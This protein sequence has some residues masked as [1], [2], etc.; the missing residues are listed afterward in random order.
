[1]KLFIVLSLCFIMWNASA[2]SSFHTVDEVSVTPLDVKDWLVAFLDGFD[3]EKYANSTA[4]C[5]KEGG[6][7]YDFAAAGVEN[8]LKKNYF[9]GSLNI[10]DALGELSP[11]SRTCYD[12]TEQLAKNFDEYIH[13]FSG[14]SDFFTKISLN[15]M[16]NIKPIKS[17]AT[18]ILTEYLVGGNYTHMAFLSGQIASLTF[19]I[20]DDYEIIVGYTEADPLAP[21]P[22]NDYLWITFEGLYKFGINSKFVSEPVLRN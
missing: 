12:T 13:S 14:L 11:L 5:K 17:K 10:S 21:N 18:Q 16:T 4:K 2:K 8:Y 9:I 22:I 19:V 20:G 15:V 1:M 3:I 6:V 7:L